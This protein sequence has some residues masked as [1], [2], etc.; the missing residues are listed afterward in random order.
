MLLLWREA[1]PGMVAEA[2]PV[3]PGL[4][5]ALATIS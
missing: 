5:T 1:D 4:D 2:L 3:M